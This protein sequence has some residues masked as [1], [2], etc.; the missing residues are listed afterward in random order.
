MA[1]YNKNRAIDANSVTIVANLDGLNSTLSALQEKAKDVIR[2]ATQAAADVF[3]RQVRA[4][5]QAMRSGTGNLLNSI[6]QVYSADQ[7]NETHAVYHVSWNHVK[8][9]HGRLIENG[10][11]RRYEYYKDAQGRIRPRVRPE[12]MGKKKPPSGGRYRAQ[13]AAYYVTLPTPVQEPARSFLRKA[14]S[15]QDEALR[16]AVDVIQRVLL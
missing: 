8:A 13:L 2:P 5:V 7:S 11:M 6:Y 12:M 16:A 15:A 14:M 4:N 3:Y 9:P 1:R 10:W